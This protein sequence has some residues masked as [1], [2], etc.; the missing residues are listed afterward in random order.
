MKKLSTLLSISLLF[1][2]MVGY[3]QDD[4]LDMLEE[5]SKEES[6]LVEATFKGT[7]LINGH[8]VETRKKNNLDFLIS[9]RF[10]EISGGAYQFFGF[11]QSNVRFGFDYGASDRFNIGIGRNSFEKT[12]DGYLKY[13][14]LRQTTGKGSPISMTLFA[15]AAAK[16]LKDPVNNDIIT[17][18]DRLAYSSQLLIARKMSSSVSLQL[19][20]T[21]LHF[22]AI[23]P[24]HD[25]HDVYAMGV[26]GRIK[27]SQRLA[28]NF[29]YY[30]RFQEHK[31]ETYNTV[32]IGF[33]IETGGHVFQLHFTNSQSMIEKGFIGETSNNFFEGDIH[34]GFNISR[35][36]QLGNKK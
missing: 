22:N 8:S 33:D 25:E 21:F 13:R 14:L 12:Y 18:N 9:H 27:L 5:E 20:P 29:E 16:T 2:S 15:S 34:F 26:G 32:S 35:T 17:F 1:I 31:A 3:G 28:L 7:R 19:M 4:L 23:L 24:E 6:F 10:G 11:D 36:F 30:Y